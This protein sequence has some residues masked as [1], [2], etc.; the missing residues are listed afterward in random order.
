[1]ERVQIH[2]RRGPGRV[3]GDCGKIAAPAADQ[4]DGRSSHAPFRRHVPRSDGHALDR[5]G[6]VVLE[7]IDPDA[8]R[9]DGD[10][11]QSTG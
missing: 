10:P 2:I 5:R 3:I 1:M 7:S 6:H 9:R 4:I 8:A 11:S